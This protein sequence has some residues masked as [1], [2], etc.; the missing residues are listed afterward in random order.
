MLGIE[1][2]GEEGP[3]PPKLSQVEKEVS[4]DRN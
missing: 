1:L 2:Y 4:S 3:P